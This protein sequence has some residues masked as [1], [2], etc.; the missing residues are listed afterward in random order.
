MQNSLIKHD[1]LQGFFPKKYFERI[2][3]YFK[4][5]NISHAFFLLQMEESY[6]ITMRHIIALLVHIEFLEHISQNIF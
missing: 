4:K 2:K 1:H 6:A 5:S 3:Y